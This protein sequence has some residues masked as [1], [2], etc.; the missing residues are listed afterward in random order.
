MRLNS[1]VL[2]KLVYQNGPCSGTPRFVNH[3]VVH[4][5]QVLGPVVSIT[6]QY[7]HFFHPAQNVSGRWWPST[8]QAG[9]NGLHPVFLPS[10]KAGT[11]DVSQGELLFSR[12]FTSGSE[13]L[14]PFCFET[15]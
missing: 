3:Q 12:S 13:L 11:A 4:L 5:A 14:A 7:H 9:S 2:P 10:V 1:Q 8:L 15:V 6:P